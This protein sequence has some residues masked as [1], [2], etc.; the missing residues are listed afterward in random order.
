M[1]IFKTFQELLAQ[2]IQQTF[3]RLVLAEHA[4]VVEAPK[5]PSHGDLATNA[6]MVLAKK[7]GQ[8]PL[9][10]AKNLLA[11]LSDLEIV[12]SVAVAP[13]GFINI[14]LKNSAWHELLKQ[15]LS[16]KAEYGKC[17]LGKGKKV[18]VEYVS[19]NPTGPMHI[20][21]ARGAVYGDVLANILAKCGYEVLREF[22]VNDA[23]SQI[24][25][26]AET[27]WLR[28]QG[29]VNG[30]EVKIPDGL[31][32]GDYLIPIAQKLAQQFPGQLTREHFMQIKTFAVNEMM[33]LVKADLAD[34]GIKHD[35]F[36]SEQTLHDQ[37][38]ITKVVEQLKDR[39]IIYEGILPEPKGKKH[40]EWD[41]R[42][43]L[44][45]KTSDFGDDQDRPLQKAD[46]SWTYFAADVA[47]FENKIQ[48][49]FDKLVLVLGAD[50]AGYIKR[51]EAVVKSI[52]P[53]KEC[54]I[55]TCQ[56][57]NYLKGGKAMKM[58]KRA[59]EFLTV[60]DIIELVGKDVI[61]FMMLTRKNDVIID[62]DID[63]LYEYSKDN[64][65]FYVQY[66]YARICSVFTNAKDNIPAALAKLNTSQIDFSLLSLEQELDLIKIIAQWPKILES[67]ALFFEPHRVV[68]YLQNLASQF[69][70]LWSLEF[71]AVAYR[72]V[73][74]DAD[75]TASRL[76]LA[77]AVQILLRQ[78][79]ELLGVE[80]MEK[81]S[82]RIA[83][84]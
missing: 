84:N 35:V 24:N 59:G 4:I 42:K 77:Y 67:S 12:E 55:K 32:P 61:R 25:V 80:P 14:R 29:Y 7:V 51:S 41:S 83:D 15:V 63:A 5:D 2:I 81:M 26:L 21:H 3:P 6:A 53:S 1:N 11:K 39:D 68:F 79:L 82:R 34:L 76:S 60:K 65:V 16:L 23:G 30:V 44:L 18:N 8:N 57:V 36:F 13:P 43:Q 48:R 64:P 19:C 37:G 56:L 38:I 66:A 31:Y 22:Y 78:G 74:A 62:F 69:H 75:V 73:T 47:Y 27:V 49:G 45:F 70:H 58:S 72:F 46:G 71:N 52:D 33:E 9:D 28:Y 40:Q 17:D 20:G 54:I 50:H 10:L